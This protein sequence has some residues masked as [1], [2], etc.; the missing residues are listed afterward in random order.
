MAAEETRQQA[1]E[2]R[3]L[4]G[5]FIARARELPT[6]PK[7]WTANRQ[8]EDAVLSAQGYPLIGIDVHGIPGSSRDA[9][10]VTA[11]GLI[12][13]RFAWQTR[14]RKFREWRGDL[15]DPHSTSPK[16]PAEVEEKV[17]EIL[18][19]HHLS[20]GDSLSETLEVLPVEEV[21]V[22]LRNVHALPAIL[23]QSLL[24]LLP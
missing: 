19:V 22:L 8:F 17:P 10:M 6:D 2:V 5:A 21:R 24:A 11:P 3:C 4:L 13:R 1:A 9:L 14:R 7:V 12:L 18:I 16:L 20:Y 23:E 15:L